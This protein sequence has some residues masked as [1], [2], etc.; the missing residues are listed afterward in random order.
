VSGERKRKEGIAGGIQVHFVGE[1][2]RRE[3]NLSLGNMK[4]TQSDSHHEESRLVKVRRRN[5]ILYNAKHAVQT[6]E[7]EK[8][9]TRRMEKTLLR[10]RAGSDQN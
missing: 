4:S 6:G 3:G 7:K 10:I 9:N 1:T 8:K 5:I 2:T